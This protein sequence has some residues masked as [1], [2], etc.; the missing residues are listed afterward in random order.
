MI[1]FLALT[2]TLVNTWGFFAFTTPLY[3]TDKFFEKFSVLFSRRQNN[4]FTSVFNKIGKKFPGI[5]YRPP[6]KLWKYNIFTIVCL[7]F[8]CRE[9]GYHVTIAHD[10]LDL[11]IQYILLCTGTPWPSPLCTGTLLARAP[12]VPAC[13]IW[14]PRLGTCSNFLTWG[15]HSC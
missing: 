11:T 5:C 3:S 4:T 8:C 6:T 15:P 7:S 2:H 1:Q 9:G 10:A 12:S 13:D 14:W